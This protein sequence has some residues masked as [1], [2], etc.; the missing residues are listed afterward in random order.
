VTRRLERASLAAALLAA[1]LLRIGGLGWGLRHRP[2]ADERYF[3][4]NVAAM[5][6]AGDLDH[7][8]YEYPGLFFYLLMP[9]LAAAGAREQTGAGVYLTARGLVAAFGVLNVALVHR[10]G[11]RMAGPAAAA[12]AAWLTA[13]SPVDVATAHMVRPDVV[14]ATIA[15]LALTALAGLD[16]GVAGDRRAGLLI[17]AASAVKFTGLLLLPSYLAQRFAAPGRRAAGIL[18]AGAAAAAAFAALSPFAVLRAPEFFEGARTQIVYHFDE[19]A[20]GRAGTAAA[21]FAFAEGWRKALGPTGTALAVAGLALAAREGRRWAFLLVF[22]AATLVA[23]SQSEFHFERHLV[24]SFGVVALL[25]GL[26]LARLAAGRPRLA[27]GVGLVALAFPL[28]ASLSY[29]RAVSSPGTRDRAVDW[30][31]ANVPPGA[32]VLSTI[33]GLGLDRTR[34]EVLEVTRLGGWGPGLAREADAVVSSGPAAEQA[35]RQLPVAWAARP[36]SPFQGRVVRVRR[37]DPAARALY[38]AVPLD[39]AALS[40]S[41]AAD[42]LEALRDGRDATAWTARRRPGRR[43]WLQATWPDPV[44]LARIEL[45]LPEGDAAARG[46]AVAVSRDG[47]RFARVASVAARPA[48]AAQLPPRSQV[49]LIEPARVRGV[50]VV[51]TGK[52]ARLWS[53]AELRLH[54]L[55][56]AASAQ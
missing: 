33:P 9:V 5:L 46:L 26:A 34:W 22:P 43:E 38:V 37:A 10:L 18:V 25:A 28:A 51:Q 2:H 16:A 24:P 36:E 6:R 54:G 31:A 53:V 55:S 4:E 42:A 19:P 44:A 32:R 14:L 13:V 30:I 29:V 27:A 23:F 52:P 40:A 21:A 17:G 41:Q 12:A 39:R 20:G 7:R 11:R 48:P 8:Y 47:V 56:R 1:L 50:R 3:V 45:L 49:L 35:F 15:L